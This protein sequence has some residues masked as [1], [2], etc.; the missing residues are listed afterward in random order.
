MYRT[1]L[2]PLDGSSLAERALPF[3]IFL[4]QSSGARILLLRAIGAP[5]FAIGDPIPR[6]SQEMRAA[7]NYLSSI[8]TTVTRPTVVEAATFTGNAADAIVEEINLRQVD[9]V[10][11]ST[12]GR[13]GFG[14]WVYGSV[15]DA[16]VRRGACPTILVPAMARD[17]PDDRPLRILV[18]LDGSELSGQILPPVADLA[19]LLDVSIIVLRVVEPPTRAIADSSTD[20]ADDPAAE[21]AAARVDLEIV[22]DGL[23][24]GGKAVR[25]ATAVGS[26]AETIA[27]TALDERADLIAMSTHGCGGLTRLLLG[28]VTT[29][30]IRRASGPILIVRP[31]AMAAFVNQPEA[32]PEVRGKPQPAVT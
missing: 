22:A 16:V 27:R 26:P 28:S 9:L 24:A 4:A 5:A 32:V 15:A 12:H 20:V 10:V 30:V 14:R 29:D 3:G 17:W 2:V 31:R 7:D 18:P 6:I 11:M 1:I 8:A 23:R 25:V 19:D 21:S 13:S